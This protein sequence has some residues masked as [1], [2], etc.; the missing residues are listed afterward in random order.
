MTATLQAVFSIS[1]S[2]LCNSNS[3][4]FL[5]LRSVLCLLALLP[6][7][8]AD[9]IYVDTYTI[10]EHGQHRHVKVIDETRT[11]NN[12]IL[13]FAF[14]MVSLR[15]TSLV[16]NII[17]AFWIALCGVLAIYGAEAEG[18]VATGEKVTTPLADDSTDT[19]DA[20]TG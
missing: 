18:L 2:P 13:L 17:I 6:F 14:F 20:P 10:D 16:L 11:C 9:G 12:S 7:H 1:N 15:L 19:V 8:M 4:P 3:R 5:Y